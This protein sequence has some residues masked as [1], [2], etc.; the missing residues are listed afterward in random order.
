MRKQV[1]A[2]AAVLLTA[3]S[4]I[5][6][7]PDGD[8]GYVRATAAAEARTQYEGTGEFNLDNLPR[9]FVIS[10]RETGSTGSGSLLFWRRQT[11]ELPRP[12][13]YPI[14]PPDDSQD[15]WD[16]FAADYTRAA[17]G[18]VESFVARSGQVEI[19]RVSPQRVEG[20]FRFAGVR[21]CARPAPGSDARPSGPCDPAAVDLAAPTI[22]VS[23]SFSAVPLSTEATPAAGP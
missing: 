14:A 4:N 5:N 19:T 23:G 1:F 15:T 8:V 21:N 18:G 7:V 10:S 6:L 17:S 11:D 9:T 16:G 20:T 12:G 2:S 13:V 3:C 22:E